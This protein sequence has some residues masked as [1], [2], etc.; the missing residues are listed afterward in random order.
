MKS[1]VR[2]QN[3]SSHQEMRL[4]VELSQVGRYRGVRTTKSLVAARCG[5]WTRKGTLVDKLVILE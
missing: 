3:A 2:A 1:G 4:P 5:S